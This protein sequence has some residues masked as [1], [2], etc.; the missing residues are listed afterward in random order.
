[1][2]VSGQ[3]QSDVVGIFAHGLGLVGTGNPYYVTQEITNSGP[4]TL[5]ELEIA[6]EANGGQPLKAHI[7]GPTL[8]AESCELTSDAPDGYRND[9]AFPRQ[10]TLDFARALAEEAR[11]LTSAAGLPI[12]Y[13]QIDEPTLSYGAD[14]DLARDAVAIIAEASSAPTIL[15][16]CGDIADI[17]ED[18]LKMPVDILNL[19]QQYLNEIPWLDSRRLA[20]SDK[21]LALGCVPVNRSDI[22]SVPALERELFFAVERYGK[23]HIWGLT[24]NCGLRMSTPDKAR[25]RLQRI[26]EIAAKVAPQFEG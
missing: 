13:L 3:P 4:I 18:L 23:E 5:R 24:P 7:T 20:E 8:L 19:E 15:H 10:L 26:A 16:V 2:Y 11:F 25:E 9:P 21:L 17:M 6:A 22:P 14:L 12:K 1:V